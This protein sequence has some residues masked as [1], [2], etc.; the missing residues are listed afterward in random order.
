MCNKHGNDEKERLD[1]G[2][3]LFV[4]LLLFVHF[5]AVLCV[6]YLCAAA[7][8]FNKQQCLFKEGLF[9]C[10]QTNSQRIAASLFA[11]DY[12]SSCLTFSAP[13]A[14]SCDRMF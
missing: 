4:A 12:S 8:D 7:A 5:N 9:L 3:K 10:P 13:F 6:I 2:I 1:T 14:A 11:D